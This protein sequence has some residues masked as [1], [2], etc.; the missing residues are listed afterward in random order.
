MEE[1]KYWIALKMVQ[2]VGEV[3]FRN[4]LAKFPSPKS[5]FEAKLSELERVEGIG[6]KIAKEIKGFKDWNKA[7]EEVRKIKKF[8]FKL[9]LLKDS[10]YPRNLFNTYNPPPFLY[11][12][13]DILPQDNTAVAI[14]G[15][16]I[17]DRYGRFVTER[18]AEELAVRGVNI[19]SGMARGIDSIAHITA[20]KS[21]GRTIAVLGSGLD[22]IY[23]SEN[24]KLYD[25]ISN[26]GAVISE[27]LLGTLPESGNFPK[28]NRVISG[29]SLGVIIVQ[30]S[31]K[32]GSLITASLALEQNREVFAVPGNI[33]SK[34]SK[35][36]NRLIKE[37]AKLVESVD[38]VLSE[39]EE[40]R[41]LKEKEINDRSAFLPELSH[42]ERLIY[43]EL[44]NE[45][46]HIDEI[47]KL[48][49]IASSKALTILLSLELSGLVAQLPGKMFQIKKTI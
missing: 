8:G 22:V 6:E 2:G 12:K 39:I 43:T 25:D 38:D 44:K 34:L 42:E 47:T 15:T 33:G 29:L 49:G 37:G 21:R 48:T 13:G 14:V 32:S 31:D 41:R 5:I 46:L 1:W 23:P 24:K 19:V 28:R 30:A 40:L 10:N 7:D 45:P 3:L 35:G 16:R 17:P 36:T 27:F 11:I 18:L 4:L 26:Q 20:L 9:L